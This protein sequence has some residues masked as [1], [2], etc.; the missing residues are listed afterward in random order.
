ML[1]RDSLVC[2]YGIH[3]AFCLEHYHKT[4]DGFLSSLVVLNLILNLELVVLVISPVAFMVDFPRP[5]FESL[6]LSHCR[7]L[8]NPSPCTFPSR[9]RLCSLYP[10][11]L[12]FIP[13]SQRLVTLTFLSG[14]ISFPLRPL[15]HLKH[16]LGFPG[17][18]LWMSSLVT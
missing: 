14:R 2:S 6:L 9:R 12:L 1:Q 3:G 17:F 11:P 5:L 18:S 13:L 7:L 4:V 10:E 15:R 16:A 8:P